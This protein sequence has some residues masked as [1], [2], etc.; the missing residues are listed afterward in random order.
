MLYITFNVVT[1]LQVRILSD[2]IM[3]IILDLAGNLAAWMCWVIMNICLFH[4]F[5]RAS[6]KSC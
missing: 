3:Y 6:Y 5:P 1:G 2:S 4:K